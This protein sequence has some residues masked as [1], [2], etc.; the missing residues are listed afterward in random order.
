MKHERIT[1]K[2]LSALLA[3]AMLF[4]V[5]AEGVGYVYA[6]ELQGEDD[7]A[8]VQVQG[9]DETED[10][11]EE[12]PAEKADAQPENAESNETQEAEQEDPAESQQEDST[13]EEPA[14]ADEAAAEEEPAKADEPAEAD[15]GEEQP[16]SGETDT[17]EPEDDIV[18]SGVAR[19][20]RKISLPTNGDK[21]IYFVDN[22]NWSS[23]FGGMWIWTWDPAECVQMTYDEELSEKLGNGSKIFYVF[24]S[25]IHDS[26]LFV[27]KDVSGG[28][29][30]GTTQSSN[31]TIGSKLN[32]KDNLCYYADY[33]YQNISS[34]SELAVTLKGKTLY[35]SAAN[36]EGAAIKV[37]GG[38]E[39]PL[40]EVSGDTSVL[41]YT[42]P[43]GLTTCYWN[44]EI[45]IV[46]DGESVTFK[47][48]DL[49]KDKVVT[50]DNTPRMSVY[51]PNLHTRYGGQTM[52]FENLSGKDLT[53]VQA[54]FYE[55]DYDTEQLLESDPV[56]VG[57]VAN[58]E[59]QT[60]TIPA[61]HWSY[62]RF[63]DGEGNTL[64]DEYSYF[65]DGDNYVNDELGAKAFQFDA[66]SDYAYRYR[67]NAEDSDWGL[68]N[69]QQVYFDAT[70][71][72]LMYTSYESGLGTSAEYSSIPSKTSSKT[73]N[74]YWRSRTPQGDGR[75]DEEYGTLS[76]VEGKDNIYLAEIPKDA[77][78]IKFSNYD[79]WFGWNNNAE[80]GEV[81]DWEEIPDL[82]KPCFYADSSDDCV[83]TTNNAYRG[84]YWDELG[85]TRNAAK[86]K[87]TDVVNIESGAFE[88]RDDMFYVNSTFYDYYTD[89][90]LN[91]NNRDGYSTSV[92]GHGSH[93]SYV[94]F[95]HFDQALS[96]A[97]KAK[98]VSIPLYTGHFQKKTWGSP[99]YEIADTLNLYGYYD[100]DNEAGFM[101]TNNSDLDVT[102]ESGKYASAAQGLVYSSLSNGTIQTSDG[103]M[104]LPHFDEDF[105][106]GDNSKNTVLGEVYHNVQFPF[107]KTDLKDNGVYYW[108]FDSSKTT[109]A[110]RYDPNSGYFLQDVGNQA[111]AQNV[112][113]RGNLE[114][115]PV[116]TQY[117]F[118]PFNEG[119]TGVAGSTYNY[120][121]GA[122][123]EFTFH[124]TEDGTVMDQDGN[125]VPIEFNFAGDDDVWVFI[126]G[127]L[128]LDIG[129]AHGTVS[130][131]IDFSGAGTTKTAT[132]SS[133]KASQGY[134]PNGG[135]APSGI[136]AKRAPSA[137]G[138][139]S[140][141]EISGSNTDKHTLT[142]FY[143]ERGM[144]ESNMK[145]N[146]N[147][148]D[149]NELSVEKK[150]DTENVNDL[151]DGLFS[152]DLEFTFNL[153]NLATHYGE[154]AVTS[155]EESFIP[156]FRVKQED[157]P[158][159]G[160]SV[161]G[162]LA[163]AVGAVYTSSLG[164]KG[165]SKTIDAD[166]NFALAKGET[167]TFFNQFRRGSYIAL[168]EVLEG[169]EENLY[170]PSWTV[171]DTDGK[172][173]TVMKTGVTV[174]NGSKTN[175]VDQK[176]NV[177]DDGRTE[178]QVAHIVGANAYQDSETVTR[179][180]GTFVFRG[181]SEPDTSSLLTKLSV[182]F[183][184]KVNTGSLTIQ[185]DKAYGNDELN[186]TYQFVVA[187]SNVGGL[188]LEEETIYTD[189]ISLKVGESE[190]ITGIPVG[191]E[192]TIY[193]LKTV[194]DHSGLDS[195]VSDDN[196]VTFTDG[197]V[198][199][200]DAYAVSGTI[201]NED[202]SEVTYLFKNTSH[203][204]ITVIATKVWDDAD[205]ADGLRSD[206]TFN[207]QRSDDGDTF[208]TVDTKTI[209]ALAGGDD[210]TVSWE[211][212]PEREKGKD[213]TYRVTETE[214]DGY[215]ATIVS[216]REDNVLTFVITNTHVVTPKDEPTPDTPAPDEPTPDEP[217]PDT[218]APDEP[219]PDEPT[220]DKP[221]PDEPTPDKPTPNEPTPNEPVSNEP[222]PQKEYTRRT[223]KGAANTGDDS[224]LVLW[225]ILGVA[226]LA[227]C[228]GALVLSRKK[229]NGHNG[230]HHR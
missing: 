159:Y 215:E 96:D 38:A 212:L 49:T 35:F 21:V 75:Y 142:M 201:A 59:N 147:F 67:G 210:L 166:G 107:T 99:F 133:V 120:G 18:L 17:E 43:S 15:D 163:N 220:P 195:V 64:G 97:Y 140:T 13:E 70:L 192:Y 177:V 5:A 145:V 57:D 9:S 202:G 200:I 198:N 93:R 3:F 83:Y 46:K 100:K 92:N 32:S 24:K 34:P 225:S 180:D 118:F 84:G 223:T 129:G 40:S 72:S 62:V 194:E 227:A 123:L 188:A 206:V 191:T 141:F 95:R 2:L 1:C 63:V 126:D 111:W 217:T 65:F 122:K 183:T 205:D 222:T 150:L 204:V 193:E 45:T 109:L 48:A 162:Q 216:S 71:S 182:T 58:D 165:E 113:S 79:L 22:R 44:T 157:I 66:G 80:Y 146:F 42:F 108:S 211:N 130:G 138:V 135:S 41:K 196:S 213:Y 167:A 60:F 77:A 69:R 29:W 208:T 155:G 82:T 170:T 190:T 102:G 52:A 7:P 125:P 134:T 101:S 16:Q 94:T 137:S 106:T 12:D 172:P 8:A 20:A 76:K 153:R 54:I 132:V 189:I 55:W 14:K 179:P 228:G 161:T 89:Y 104:A 81:T 47:W 197:T 115:D 10:P 185:K 23:T 171:F 105:L 221:T 50:F 154:K 78:E 103:K 174:T 187:F 128:A 136:S 87:G 149:E 226:S 152:D 51:D 186:E 19:Q 168:Q 26:F 169:Q 151:F 6:E 56:T 112:N 74:V 37:D 178:N 203:P 207:L 175:L 39:Q 110:M 30:N 68:P 98:T 143:M 31:Q 218:P 184:N 117:G 148:P 90:E 61:G 11:A 27:N 131:T 173:V 230:T 144:W 139:A 156:G 209:S 88:Y 25:Q 86:G 127:Q 158:D 53:G 4:A 91:G 160:T 33:V 121:F 164:T 229:K 28:D 176:G 116:S 36:F 214:L 73:G 119:S 124:L 219:T 85:K 114:V 224:S 181:Y 199:G